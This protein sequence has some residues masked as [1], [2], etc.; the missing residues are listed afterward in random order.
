MTKC[1]V[2]YHLFTLT[3]VLKRLSAFASKRSA[4]GSDLTT[5][6][7]DSKNLHKRIFCCSILSILGN[8]KETATNSDKVLFSSLP[9]G[10]THSSLIFFLFIFDYFALESVQILLLIFVVSTYSS[11]TTTVNIFKIFTVFEMVS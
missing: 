3:S 10:G 5:A 1:T 9:Y 6:G 4:G 11:F 2:C 8:E 7:P